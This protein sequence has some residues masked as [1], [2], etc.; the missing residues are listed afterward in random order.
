MSDYKAEIENQINLLKEEQ[1]KVKGK[2]NVTLMDITAK[3]AN[4]LSLYASIN[5]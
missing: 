3:I 2:D 1:A 5:R 4:L